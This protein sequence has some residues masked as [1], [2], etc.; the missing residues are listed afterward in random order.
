MNCENCKYYKNGKVGM[1]C[2]DCAFTRYQGK[3]GPGH[4]GGTRVIDENDTLLKDFIP[5]VLK[6]ITRNPHTNV[7]IKEINTN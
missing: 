5:N 4:V 3:L 2:I 1:P 6:W 7:I